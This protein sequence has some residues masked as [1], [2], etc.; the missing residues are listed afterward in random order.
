MARPLRIEYDGATYHITTRGN[1]KKPVFRDEE[2]RIR[3]LDALNGVEGKFN[4][5]CHAYCLMSNHYHLVIET[6]DGNLSKGMRQLNGLYTQDFNRRHD[7][8]GHLFQGRYKSFLIQKENY[9]LA[10]CRYV[11]L[12]PVRARLVI[13]PEQWRWS[14]YR[15]TAGLEEPHPC[16]TV[17]WMLGQFSSKVSS[18]TKRYAEFIRSG[19]DEE[20]LWPKLKGQTILGDE[21][22]VVRMGEYLKGAK[23]IK[24]IPRHQR[25]LGRPGLETLL[26]EEARGRKVTRDEAIVRAVEEYGFSQKEIA[27]YLALH[28]STISRI[29]AKHQM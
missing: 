24:D 19:V 7:R 13:H 16:L 14:S 2:D 3:F 25:Y 6:P 11:V 22:F 27:D 12:N 23:D 28:Y 8:V 10:V 21:G 20:A 29:I 5:L 26:G 15:A 17:D 1:E 18:A 4:W 9:L